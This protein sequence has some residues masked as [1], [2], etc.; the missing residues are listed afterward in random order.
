M[1]ATNGRYSADPGRR[2]VTTE[3]LTGSATVDASPWEHSSEGLSN[4][5]PMA[6]GI[7]TT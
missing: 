5:A 7:T 2:F 6:S 3:P 1:G 4:I